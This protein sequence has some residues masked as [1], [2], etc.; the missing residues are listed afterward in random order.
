MGVLELI[1][2]ERN[3]KLVRFGEKNDECPG[4][5][6][7]EWDVIIEVTA[8]C[9]DFNE[10][11]FSDIGIK[12]LKQFLKMQEGLLPE[13]DLKSTR[14][15]PP[16]ARP[17]KIICIGL[18]Y[19][20]HA[21]ESNSEVPGEPVLF[22][23][24]STALNGPFDPIEIPRDSLKTDWEVELAFVV[25]KRAKYITK[26]EAPSY[27]AGYA[28]MNDVSEREFQAERF[29]QWVKGKSHDTFAPFGPYLVTSDE[30]PDVQNLS[31]YLN[32]NG[33]RMQTGNTNTMIFD[34]YTLISYIS[35]FMTLLPGDI[36]STGTP[37][38]VGFGMKPPRFLKPGDVV[39]LEVEGL[40][41]QCQEII[42]SK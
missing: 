22:T 31:M 4:V 39:E 3:M 29:G 37:P 12:K 20:D 5:L 41:K 11:F 34:V 32:V 15:A 28:V 24:A 35:Q 36:I 27:I 38:G 17:S 18:N 14:L 40:G 19:S 6:D 42:Q 13:Y 23:K 7:E 33:E 30:V 10:E 21:K 8:L 25:G 1:Y 2:K 9:E 16:V 26:E